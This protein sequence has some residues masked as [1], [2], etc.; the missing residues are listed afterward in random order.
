MSLRYLTTCC[1]LLVMTSRSSALHC[2]PHARV[3]KRTA[4]R[5]ATQTADMRPHT[6]RCEC[7][8]TSSST[9]SWSSGETEDE[10][11]RDD[12]AVSALGECGVCERWRDWN[13][14]ARLDSTSTMR[15]ERRRFFA[16]TPVVAL[17]VPPCTL[18]MVVLSI[19]AAAAAVLAMLALMLAA[20]PG[21]ALPL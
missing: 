16:C 11:V 18:S 8:I 21:L 17:V 9:W 12:Q 20:R 5:H 3:F 13:V 7:S 10:E 14:A 19:E 1:A 2:A 6:S 4:V 15:G